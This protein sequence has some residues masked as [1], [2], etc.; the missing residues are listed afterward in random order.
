MKKSINKRTYKEPSIRYPDSEYAVNGER[1]DTPS[2]EK[3]RRKF[4]LFKQANP[5][6]I[7]NQVIL[8]LLNERNALLDFLG[9]KSLID[10]SIPIANEEAKLTQDEVTSKAMHLLRSVNVTAGSLA[11]MLRC[12][13]KQAE[14][15]IREIQELK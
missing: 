3:A 5:T 1:R 9:W 11:V 14:K 15:A 7:R 10:E 2:L 12:S 13:T 8:N 6:D 4:Y